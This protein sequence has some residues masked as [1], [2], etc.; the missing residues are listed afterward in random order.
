MT[1]TGIEIESLPRADHPVLVAGFDGWGNA[2]NISKALV[3]FIVRQLQG[4]PFARL[5][6]DV[7]YRYDENRPLVTIEHGVQKSLQAPGGQF[8]YIRTAADQSDV[9]V[10]E[11]L[12]PALRWYAFVDE[13]MALCSRLQVETVI[14]VGSMWDNV[15]H[16]DRVISGTASNDRLLARLDELQVVPIYYQGP[17]AIHSLIHHKCQQNGLKSVSLWSHCPYYLQETTH[18]G[19]L[20]RLGQLV[21]ELGKFSLDV[22]ELDENWAQLEIQIQNLIENNPKIKEIVRQLEKGESR[23][24]WEG[25]APKPKKGSK[26]INLKDFQNPK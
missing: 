25:L 5:N 15:L 12:E 11:A 26:I 23:G 14:T 17:G 2:L 13:M 22:K 21:S 19:I 10:L 7:F 16:T 1:E 18:F 4:Q 6:P 8:A 24:S 9:V 3:G 20:S